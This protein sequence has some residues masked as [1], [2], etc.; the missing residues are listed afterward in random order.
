MRIWAYCIGS[1]T[2]VG[3]FLSIFQLISQSANTEQIL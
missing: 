3:I 2:K 1:I